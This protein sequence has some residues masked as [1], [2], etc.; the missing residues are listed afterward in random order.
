MEQKKSKGLPEE[1]DFLEKLDQA[2]REHFFNM[3]KEEQEK[4]IFENRLAHAEARVREENAEMN[5]L[6]DRLAS[7]SFQG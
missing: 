3:T 6:V 2:D 1:L 4:T 5:Q 7:K